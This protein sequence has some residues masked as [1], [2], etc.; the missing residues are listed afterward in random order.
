MLRDKGFAWPEAI[1]KCTALPADMTWLKKGRIEAGADADI[2][3]F[4]ACRLADRATFA[5]QLLPPD[6]IEWVIIGGAPAVQNN[7]ILDG[8]KGRLM[9]RHDS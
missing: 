7:K 8:P 6:G 5:E 3:I 1:R 2:V 9:N 4:D